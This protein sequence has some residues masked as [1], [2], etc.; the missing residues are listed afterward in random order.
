MTEALFYETSLALFENYPV[1]TAQAW[2][3]KTRLRPEKMLPALLR[4]CRSRLDSE[5][6]NSKLQVMLDLVK[7]TQP[8]VSIHNYLVILHAEAQDSD[9]FLWRY[10]K[11]F[12]HGLFGLQFALRTFSPETSARTRTYI[13]AS[14]GLFEDAV[15]LALT[16]DVDLAKDY[17]KLPEIPLG[18][19]M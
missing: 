2:A 16:I 11:S 3:C 13:Y 8:E 9:E 14:L 17:A 5:A 1:P 6:S 4:S 15:G 7:C 18:T 12:S 10:L 19:K